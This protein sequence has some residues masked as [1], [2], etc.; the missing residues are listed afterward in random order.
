MERYTVTDN[1]VDDLIT[2]LQML[3]KHGLPGT[4]VIEAWN[5]D[6]EALEPITGLLY[7]E[8]RVEICTDDTE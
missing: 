3:K 5:P 4:A 7:D 2:T 6:M 8:A 1:T